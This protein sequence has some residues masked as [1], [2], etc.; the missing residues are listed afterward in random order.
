MATQESA[1]GEAIAKQLQTAEAEL[2][3][4]HLG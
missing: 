1:L 4:A 2:G 3:A